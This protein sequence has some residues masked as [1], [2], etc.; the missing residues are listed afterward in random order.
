MVAFKKKGID[1]IFKCFISAIKKK[2]V[3]KRQERMAL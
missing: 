3:Q 2:D 1:A